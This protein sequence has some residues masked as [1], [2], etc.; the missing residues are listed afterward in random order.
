MGRFLQ[1]QEPAGRFLRGARFNWELL[2]E[3]AFESALLGLITVPVRFVTDF[4][5]IPRILWRILPPIDIH[6]MA[7][8]VHDFLYREQPLFGGYPGGEPKRVTRKQADLVFLEA[9]RAI[10]V[11]EWKARVMYAGVR[12]GGWLTFRKHKKRIQNEEKVFK[13]PDSVA[14]VE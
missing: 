13:S 4:A 3:L 7:A 14:F 6:R 2:E 10:D 1:D 11:P 8:I 5:S 12:A 9:M